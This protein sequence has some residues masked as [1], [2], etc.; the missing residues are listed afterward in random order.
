MSLAFVIEVGGK[1]AGLAV[2]EG[3]QYRFH[4]VAS[5]L[6]DIH[7]RIFASPVEA[8]RMVRQYQLRRPRSSGVESSQFAH[9]GC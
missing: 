3:E 5:G 4:A 9:M 2:R 6:F 8:E 7:D 1:V